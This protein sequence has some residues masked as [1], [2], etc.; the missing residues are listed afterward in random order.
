M[1]ARRYPSNRR[2]D[3]GSSGKSCVTKAW[4]ELD[5][6]VTVE[7]AI[8]VGGMTL[9]LGTPVYDTRAGR[10]MWL[11][12]VS[13]DHVTFETLHGDRRYYRPKLE[14]R[15][16]NGSLVVEADPVTGPE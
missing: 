3:P 15:V 8:E 13:G 7:Q 6:V 2:S 1:D 16:A 10:A 4:A 14:A 5:R 12:E 9:Q 11:A